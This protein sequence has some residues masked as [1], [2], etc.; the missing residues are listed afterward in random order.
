MMLMFWDSTVFNDAEKLGNWGKQINPSFF[1]CI[2]HYIERD[3]GGW[4]SF[5]PVI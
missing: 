4:S 1:Q 5:A 3:A 2:H